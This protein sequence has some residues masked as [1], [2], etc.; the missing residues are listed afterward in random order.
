M[1][2]RGKHTTVLST[3]GQ[4]ILPKAIRDRREWKAGTRLIVEDTPGGVLL[5]PEAAFQPTAVDAVF[6]FLGQ[7]GPAKSIEDMNAAVAAEAKRRARDSHQCRRSLP[8]Q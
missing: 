8:D 6:G 7:E 3:K 1:A 5:K 2:A 4:F